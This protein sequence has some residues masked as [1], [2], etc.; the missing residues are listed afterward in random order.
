MNSELVRGTF[1]MTR[2]LA[3]LTVLGIVTL[4]LEDL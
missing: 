4:T 3:C 1:A 2:F